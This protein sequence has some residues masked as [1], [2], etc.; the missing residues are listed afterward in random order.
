[1][2]TETTTVQAD[3]IAGAKECIAALVKLEESI[4]QLPS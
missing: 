1:M 2:T 4:E 3:R